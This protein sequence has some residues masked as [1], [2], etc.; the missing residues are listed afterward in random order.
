MTAT[1]VTLASPDE[2][3]AVFAALRRVLRRG[4][5]PDDVRWV[6]EQRGQPEI[7]DASAANTETE[8]Q[9]EATPAPLRLPRLHCRGRRENQ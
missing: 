9:D 8:D 6:D 2:L 4:V 7:F 5:E 3:D 1:V